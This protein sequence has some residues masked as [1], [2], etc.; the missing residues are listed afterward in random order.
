MEFEMSLLKSGMFR[1]FTVGFAL[2]A[3]AVF[4]TF[5]IGPDRVSPGDVVPTAVAAPVQ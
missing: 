4:A 2:G 3:L 5:G 1:F